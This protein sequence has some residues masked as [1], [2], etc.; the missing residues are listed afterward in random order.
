MK[1]KKKYTRIISLLLISCFLNYCV[2]Y[3][4]VV[5][6]K[7]QPINVDEKVVILHLTDSEIYLIN[8]KIENENI[9]GQTLFKTP[10]YDKSQIVHIYTDSTIVAPENERASLAIPFNSIIKVEIYDT[11][12]G[13]TVLYT[14]GG[15]ALTIGIIIL[16]IALTKESCP[17]I[18]V[19]NGETYEFTG[20]IYSGAI[21]PPLERHDY[22]PLPMLKA[23]DNEYRIKMA[24]EVHEIQYTNLAELFVIDH[25]IDSDVLV[26]KYGKTHT[27]NNLQ[28]PIGA[29]NLN[30]KP[31]LQDIVN[32]DSLNYLGEVNNE[33]NNLM[34]GM[35]LSFNRPQNVK[36]A[37]LV[38][39]AKNSFWLD[40]IYGQFYNLFG[41]AYPD[42]YE[43][44]KSAPEENLRNWSI[45]QG[46]PLS[47]YIEKNGEWE[48]IEYYNIVGP[49]AAKKDILEIDL[50]DISDAEVKIKLEYGFMFWEVDY[51][52]MD[53]SP[54]EQVQKETI[55]L[56]SAIDQ[57][58]EDVSGLLNHDDNNYQ[59]LSNIGEE[60]LLKFPVPEIAPDVRRT[61]ILHSKGH[62]EVLRN[63]QGIPDISYLESFRKPG[64]FIEFSKERFLDYYNDIKE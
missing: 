49:V 64:R 7:E 39:N 3:K 17:F 25:P 48:F 18:Y 47:V 38:I 13:K 61:V 44:Q 14:V 9:K 46:I 24:N 11:D 51:V 59:I 15:I 12:V 28:Q 27:I 36:S 20:E 41:N 34:D 57:D 62:Y 42:W 23:V 37:K 56:K 45:Q 32:M 16:I 5:V 30:E 10:R 19:F 40:Y 60:V 53:F 55:S 54:N 43:K 2:G 35:I 26:D 52:A 22:L 29:F 63:P 8:V 33:E 31:I 1:L 50:S 21:H 58:N 4:R 6:P